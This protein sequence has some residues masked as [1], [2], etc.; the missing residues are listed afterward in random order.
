MSM[1]RA[2]TRMVQVRM[3]AKINISLKVGPRRDDGFHELATVFHAVSLYDTITVEQRAAGSGITLQCGAPGVPEDASNLAWRAALRMAEAAGREADLRIRID[4]GIPTAGGMAGGSADA[5]GTMLAL[6]ELWQMGLPKERLQDLA[7]ELGSDV[8]FCIAGGTQ[9][10]SGRGEILTPVLAR[11]QY[12]W[13]IATASI[14]L[15]TPEVFHELDRMRPQAEEPRVSEAVMSSL[16][17]ADPRALGRA[18]ENDLQSPALALRPSL[19]RTLDAG[20]EA[21]ALGALVSGSGPT[22]VFLVRDD[23]HAIDVQIALSAS[24]L[25]HDA[26]RAHGPVRPQLV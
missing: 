7:A 23:E 26:V 8:P 20:I 4:K 21:G 11:G 16:R 2:R 12:H 19:R 15:P 10:G 24:G 6:N 9:L 14:G 22:C 1:S 3:P 17:A 18:L 25:T 5:A 13:V